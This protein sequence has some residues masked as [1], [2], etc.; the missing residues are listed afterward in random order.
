[1]KKLNQ[2]VKLNVGFACDKGIQRKDRKNQDAVGVFLPNFF[3]R[4]PPLLVV[5]DGMGGYAGGELA[6]KLVIKEFKKNYRRTKTVNDPDTVLKNCVC[7]AHEAIKAKAQKKPELHAMGS[8]VVA[9]IIYDKKISIINVGD[10]RAY[11]ISSDQITQLSVDH[12]WV[13]EQ[14]SQELLTPEQARKHP[15]KNRLTMSISAK[16]KEIE[17]NIAQSDLGVEDIVVLCSDGLWGMVPNSLIKSV[18]TQLSPQEAAD[19]LVELA[20]ANDG[21]DNISIVVARYA[22]SVDSEDDM[23]LLEKL[24]ETNP[25]F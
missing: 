20:N 16:R 9:A 23:D 13:E 19:K 7:S 24:D 25:G 3:F 18:V 12:S 17:S 14:I 8:T 22:E 4:R 15:Q 5:A 21:T 1:M 10:S 11:I 6:S 2:F